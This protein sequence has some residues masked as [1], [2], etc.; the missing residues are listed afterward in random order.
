MS[1]ESKYLSCA[2]TAKLLRVALKRAFSS[3]KFSVRS[4][5]YSGGASIDVSYINGASVEKVEAVAKQFAGA[6]F[7]GMID[8]KYYISH[9]LLPDGS[10]QIASSEGTESSDGRIG[11][12]KNLMPDGAKEVH[13]GADFV[14]IKREIDEETNKKVAMYLA[15]LY[16]L[17]FNGSMWREIE[18]N[19]KSYT[20][21][22]LVWSY[23]RDKDFNDF[24]KNKP[25]VVAI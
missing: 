1:E 22:G 24:F 18:V 5:V 21:G 12:I 20:F 13:F 16:N 9:Y 15:E 11:R 10:V 19:G 25:M 4:S 23:T 14:F 8:Y 7:D 17:E 6:G 2:E 3:I